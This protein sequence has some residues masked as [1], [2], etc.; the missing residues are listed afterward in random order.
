MMVVVERQDVFVSFPSLPPHGNMAKLTQIVVL[1][2]NESRI[3]SF[4]IIQNSLNKIATSARPILKSLAHTCLHFFRKLSRGAK[5][6][7]VPNSSQILLTT[8]SSSFA[9]RRQI[10]RLAA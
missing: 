3:S 2:R 5:V 9:E 10:A 4:W 8:Y 6:V 7:R 1:E